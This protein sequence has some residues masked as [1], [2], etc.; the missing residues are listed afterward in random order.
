MK[1]LRIFIVVSLVMVA[2]RNVSPEPTET[3][4]PTDKP[5]AT[6]VE[7]TDTPE[8][9]STPTEEPTETPTKTKTPTNTPVAIETATETTGPALAATTAGDSGTGSSPTAKPAQTNTP[10]GQAE[11]ATK[12]LEPS[13][14]GEVDMVPDGQSVWQLDNEPSST[15]TSEACPESLPLDFYGLVAVEKVSD[16]VITWLTPA[17]TTYTLQ[18]TAGETNVYWGRGDFFLPDYFLTISVVFTSPESLGVTYVLIHQTIEGCNHVWK[19][20][21]FRA[22]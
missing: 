21:G 9:S 17:G 14:A 18:R 1:W 2:C 19:Y 16:G 15:A 5:T 20:G 7:E 12:T 11:P 13:P 6:T 4:K 22:W 3:P 10:T 8:P